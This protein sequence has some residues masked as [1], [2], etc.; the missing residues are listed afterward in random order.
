VRILQ[1][2][3]WYP[4]IIG[5]IERH[6]RNL[7]TTLV[8]RGHH[9]AVVALLQSGLPEYEEREGV[10]IY[11]VKGTVQ[12]LSG[13]FMDEH[14]RAAA[15]I[16]DPE[17]VAALSRII[18]RERPDIVHGHNW[19][20]H[21]F[22]PLRRLADAPLIV[23]LH[24]FSLIC[25]RWDLMQFGQ[26]NCTGPAI[27]K[28]LRCAAR[29]YGA[30]KAVA[31]VTGTLF[32][33][34][35]ERASVDR[36]IAVSKSV[37]DDNGL[38]SRRLPFSIIPNFVPDEV[39]DGS[40]AGLD[41]PGLPDEPFLLYVGALTRIKGVPILFHA[42]SRLRPRP[43]LML[44]GYPG[45]ETRAL[46]RDLPEGATFLENQPHPAVLTAWRRS[47]LGVVPSV[48][49][50]PCATVLMEAM[51]AGAPIVA[52]RIGGNPDIVEDGVNGLLVEP[53]SIDGLRNAIAR[54]INDPD[55]ANRLRDNGR[56]AAL[57]FAAS[58]V[59]PR[60]ER[61]YEE[62]LHMRSQPDAV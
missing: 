22:L 52:S 49:R 54:I 10:R 30:G 1:I 37:A 61:L 59:V 31:T 39:A 6:V 48:W 14:R 3:Q 60:I 46:L 27:A 23:T 47:L 8:A 56:K 51:G 53:G 17:I 35:L 40:I 45:A 28:C 44:I 13:L 16:P 12:R 62:L 5:G 34:E 15:P 55:L 36:F 57:S 29:H 33:G 42:Y 38:A 58:V 50:E 19:L 43:R 32:M 7:S 26:V 41:V 2:A 24:D 20:V 11:R 9:V 18:R 25:A 21:S 4:P